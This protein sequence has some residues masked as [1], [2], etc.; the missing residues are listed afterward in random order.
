MTMKVLT[1][2][3]FTLHRKV[4]YYVYQHLICAELDRNKMWH[5]DHLIRSQTNPAVVTGKP[6]LMFRLPAKHG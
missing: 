6:L 4:C 1:D 3:H 5:N 2:K